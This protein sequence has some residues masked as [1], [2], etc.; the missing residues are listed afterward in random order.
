M[1]PTRRGRTRSLLITGRARIQLSH[2]GRRHF[3]PS[4]RER[5][6]AAIENDS[7]ETDEMSRCEWKRTSDMR[8]E[9][10]FKSVCTSSQSDQSLRCLHEESL[11]HEVSSMRPAMILNR[12]RKVRDWTLLMT[13]PHSTP[14]RSTVWNVPIT[15][16][17]LFKYIEN[18][19]TKNWQIS[20]KKFLYFSY[21]CLKHRLWRGGS[22][23]YPRSIFLSRNKKNNVYPYKP[24]FPK[25]HQDITKTR[26]FKY[27]E[28]FT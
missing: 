24:Q 12:L 5:E 19:T 1:L 17:R 8:A 15:K 25:I 23:E 27:I 22:N 18:F 3:V 26:V 4:P 11:H 28:N 20:D 2:R 13:L 6:E 21:F 10:R 16:I 9:R 7:E 14:P